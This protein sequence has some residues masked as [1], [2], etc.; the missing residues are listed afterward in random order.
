MSVIS[1]RNASRF[2]TVFDGVLFPNLFPTFGH[3]VSETRL[4]VVLVRREH[5]LRIARRGIPQ[6]AKREMPLLPKNVSVGIGGHA[7][8][9]MIRLIV[10]GRAT[11]HL[12]QQLPVAIRAAAFLVHISTKR[13]DMLL[14]EERYTAGVSHHISL[15]RHVFGS[16]CVGG[17]ANAV[18]A[19]LSS[20]AVILTL[21]PLMIGCV[22]PAL[23]SL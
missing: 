9:Q 6:L 16:A 22:F 13:R 5:P 10:R 1:L 23:L 2:C 11:T 20:C 4:L 18:S 8:G 7:H 15:F 14:A 17:L 21:T 12:H 19:F 3:S